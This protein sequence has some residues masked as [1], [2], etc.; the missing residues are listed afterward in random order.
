MAIDKHGLEGNGHSKQKRHFNPFPN[1]NFPTCAVGIDG[2]AQNSLVPV[3]PSSTAALPGLTG[4]G[5]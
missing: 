5:P 2:K 1:L 4:F 3:A